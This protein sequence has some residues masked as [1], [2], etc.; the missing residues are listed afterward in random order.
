MSDDF[1]NNNP[2]NNTPDDEDASASAIF[3]EMMRQAAERRS[4][5]R[6][7]DE[8]PDES[9][10]A[11]PLP[12]DTYPAMNPMDDDRV[13]MSQV[14]PPSQ[15]TK[16]PGQSRKPPTR[17]VKPRDNAPIL[18]QSLQSD[19]L[20]DEEKLA[21]AMEQQRIQRVKRRKER[22]RRR[23]VGAL[24]G[25][26]RTL[27]VMLISAGL[28]ATILTWFTDPQFLNPAVVKGL[29]DSHTGVLL[30]DMTTA[31][32]VQPTQIA[33]PNWLQRIGIISGH[34]GPENDPGAVCEDGLTESEINFDV[35]QRVVRN[36]RALNYTVDLLDEFDPRLD[37]YQAAALVSIHANTC[38]D[39]GER[40][41]G[42]LVAKAASR[43]DGGIDN[44]LEQCISLKYEELIPLERRYTLTLDMT[45]YHTFREIH[46]L[47]PAAIIEL[48]FMLADRALLTEQPDLIAQAITNGVQCF[49]QPSDNR[50]VLPTVDD[51]P[52]NF[53]PLA[54]E[55]PL[56]NP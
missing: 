10:L 49:L 53:A 18:P 24:G 31:P 7:P 27:F 42:Y 21:E 45:D 13:P 1:L 8:V 5:I 41:S 14:K 43:P 16:P 33:T 11:E 22:R 25:F 12:D 15:P 47:T 34:R 48:G 35:A 36:L 9:Q 28:V 32:T 17:P 4:P 37:N 56:P 38:Q 55:T 52:D 51:I 50:P 26:F 6:P 40:V 23:T 44:I 39:F 19:T 29:Q 46:P 3:A 2:Q 20:R 54:T 30:D